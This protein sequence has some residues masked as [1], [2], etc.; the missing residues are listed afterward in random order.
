[1]PCIPGTFDRVFCRY[2]SFA[3]PAADIKTTASRSLE[4]YDPANSNFELLFIAKMGEGFQ[5]GDQDLAFATFIKHCVQSS[6]EMLSINFMLDSHC[7]AHLSTLLRM[8]EFE[9]REQ[10]RSA[11]RAQISHRFPHHFVSIPILSLLGYHSIVTFT[12][13]M[14][15]LFRGKQ[16]RIL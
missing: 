6:E 12:T 8:S 14:R 5:R 16:A 4:L 1:M 3:S 15:N 9:H 7:L 10:S 13:H 11:F 2:G